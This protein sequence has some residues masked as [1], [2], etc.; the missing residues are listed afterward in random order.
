MK[1]HQINADAILKAIPSNWLD[2]LLS[3]PDAVIKPMSGVGI[4]RLLNAIR[5]RVRIAIAKENRRLL[6]KK[7]S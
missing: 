6:R 3:G 2:P 5:E 7:K 1:T 4:E